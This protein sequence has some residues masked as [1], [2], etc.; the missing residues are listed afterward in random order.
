VKIFIKKEEEEEIFTGFG[1]NELH[2]FL[3]ALYNNNV[4]DY[5]I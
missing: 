4:I 2:H 3:Q 5:V 1:I